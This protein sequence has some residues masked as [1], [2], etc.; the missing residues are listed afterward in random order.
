MKELKDFE[1]SEFGKPSSPGVYAIWVRNQFY[2]PGENHLLYIGS[3]ANLYKR[4]NSNKHYYKIT[5]NKFN[6]LVWTSFIETND[7]RNLEYYLI[8]KHKPILNKQ[9]NNGL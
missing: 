4:L 1:I 3:T 6:G 9:L 8:G 7:Y 2:E 5:L